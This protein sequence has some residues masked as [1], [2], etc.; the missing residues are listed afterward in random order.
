[1]FEVFALVQRLPTVDIDLFFKCV[2][3]FKAIF[4]E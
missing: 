1:M 4:H 3:T 2:F